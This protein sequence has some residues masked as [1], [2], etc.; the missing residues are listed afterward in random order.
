MEICSLTGFI[1]MKLLAYL[2]AVL[3]FFVY[4]RYENGQRSYYQKKINQ[5]NITL[6]D[7]NKLANSN[8]AS[9]TVKQ[10]GKDPLKWFGML[11]PR[12]LRRNAFRI[13]QRKPA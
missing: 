3:K 8:S 10:L 1:V 11:V 13:L 5:D 7:F 4:F 9:M 12:S 2:K 6:N